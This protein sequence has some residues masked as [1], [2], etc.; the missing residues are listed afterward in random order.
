MLRVL[1]SVTVNKINFKRIRELA[2]LGKS[3]GAASVRYNS[4]FFGGNAAC[5][6]KELMLT[7]SE[8]W[9][10]IGFIK[11]ARKEFGDFIAGSC[12]QEVDILKGLKYKK[13]KTQTSIKINPCGAATSKCYI[14]PDGNVTPCELMW[15]LKAGNIK[16]SRFLDI[17]KNSE[18]M[19]GFRKPMIY[20]LKDHPGCM[21]CGYKRLCYQGHRC[22]PYYFEK[23]LNIEE[24]NCLVDK[25]QRV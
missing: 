15:N 1:L 9:E 6:S 17:W 10:L 16:E 25:R 4:M 12:L 11:E 3:L 21:G 19:R 8:R 18:V 13:V 7:P 22:S 20:S 5:N 24:V 2:L 14:A 23:D